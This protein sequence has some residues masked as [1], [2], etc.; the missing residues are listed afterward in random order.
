[1]KQEIVRRLCDSGIAEDH[2][3]GVGSSK[4]PQYLLCATRDFATEV[5]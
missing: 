4:T 5:Q 1:M 3:I 2:V